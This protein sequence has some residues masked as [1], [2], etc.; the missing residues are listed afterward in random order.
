MTLNGTALPTLTKSMDI[1]GPGAEVLTI[2]GNNK[3]RIFTANVAD[4]TV[5]LA[6]MTL[7]NGSL[8]SG[9]GGAIALTAVNGVLY[10]L[11]IQDSQTAGY[12]GGGIYA[13]GGDSFVMDNC[14]ITGNQ[15]TTTSTYG[16]GAWISY[17]NDVTIT[18][19]AFVGNESYYGGGLTLYSNGNNTLDDVVL[20][21]NT[22]Y[23][24]GGLYASRTTSTTYLDKA[25]DI[26][27]MYSWII[28]NEA[29]NH[30]GGAVFNYSE[31]VA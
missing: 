1:L 29:T 13:S 21:N 18:N 6:G 24:G 28:D 30:S 4:T 22:A 27:I 8:A 11:V 25:N 16:G 15:T 9:S 5:T 7:T 3:S 10:D 26:T 20:E 2:S 23:N 17:T 19:S 31:N 12:Y 14:L